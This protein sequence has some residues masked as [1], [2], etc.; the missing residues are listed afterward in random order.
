MK[1]VFGW[2]GFVVLT[3]CVVIGALAYFIAD[4]CVF[5]WRTAQ[6]WLDDL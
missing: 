6:E 2:V 5:G 4:A 3:P 1:R